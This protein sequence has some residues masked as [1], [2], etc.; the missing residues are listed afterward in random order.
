[1]QRFFIDRKDIQL[2]LKVS[3]MVCLAALRALCLGDSKSWKGSYRELAEESGC[4][5]K[6][7]AQRA[8]EVLIQR[9]L[10]KLEDGVFSMTHIETDMTQNETAMTQNE[11]ESKEKRTKKENN[12]IKDITKDNNSSLLKDVTSQPRQPLYFNSFIPPT[13]DDI[14]LFAEEKDMPTPFYKKFYAYYSA[15]GWTLKGGKQMSNWKAALTYWWEK[16]KEK[17][18]VGNRGQFV[19]A[20]EQEQASYAGSEYTAYLTRTEQKRQEELKREQNV[21]TRCVTYEEFKQMA[22]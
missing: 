15:N 11:T 19:R 18:Q 1:M 3:E 5:N 22:G 8:V 17:P 10:V 16:E 9:G 2:G 4:G 6:D 20:T 14:V 13:W 7:T 12:N 21:E